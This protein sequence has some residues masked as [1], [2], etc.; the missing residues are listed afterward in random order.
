M[1][2]AETARQ[3]VQ[4]ALSRKYKR[5]IVP[6]AAKRAGLK[7]LKESLRCLT[8]NELPPSKPEQKPRPPQMKDL[9][10]EPDRSKRRQI[11]GELLKHDQF[12]VF[13]Y[14]LSD[15]HAKPPATNRQ[16]KENY[17]IFEREHRS[18]SLLSRN[19]LSD[20]ASHLRQNNEL[21]SQMKSKGRQIKEALDL[22]RKSN[23]SNSLPRSANNLPAESDN[24]LTKRKASDLPKPQGRSWLAAQLKRKGF[25]TGRDKKNFFLQLRS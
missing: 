2:L 1:S 8:N 20:I 16:A 4:N 10:A 6:L 13:D 5:T 23:K 24:D 9:L 11:V 17:M 3:A 14:I 22:F 15:A 21:S 18:K 12:S 25:I 7:K 19:L